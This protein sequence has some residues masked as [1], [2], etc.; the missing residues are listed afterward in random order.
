MASNLRLTGFPRRQKHRG[1]MSENFDV[2]ATIER[3]KEQPE[4]EQDMLES[5]R[6]LVEML[7]MIV[8]LLVNKPGLNSRN[9]S[10]SPSTDPNRKKAGKATSRKK[11]GAQPGHKGTT[12][13]RVDDPD[14]I[15]VLKID[16]STLPKGVYKQVGY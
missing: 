3:I 15:E 11:R 9:S 2:S 4:E 10:K 8:T 5:M 12:L 14:Q 16:Q 7:L 6:S 1:G 13:Q